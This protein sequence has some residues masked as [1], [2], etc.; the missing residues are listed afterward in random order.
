MTKI[1]DL[2]GSKAVPQSTSLSAQLPVSLVSDDETMHWINSVN[3]EWGKHI[4]P[5]MDEDEKLWVQEPYILKN[6]KGEDLE[7]VISVTMNDARVFGERVLSV[8]NE[9]D[10]LIEVNGQRNGK[11][12]DGHES[13]VIED[14]WYD[15]LYLANENLNQILMPDLDPYLWEQIGIRGRVGVRILLSQDENGFDVDILPIDMRKC[16]YSVGKRGLSKVAFWDTLDKD[17]CKEEY[18]DYKPVAE[19]IKRWDY[20]DGRQEII[21]LDGKPLNEMLPN[22][23]GHPP[24]VI[25]LCQQGTFLDTSSRALR[26]RGDSLFSANRELYPELNRISSILQTMNQLSLSPPQKLKS[27]SGKKFPVDP[28]Y[29]AGRILGLE[30]GEDIEKIESPDIQGSTRFFM[31]SL[32]GALQRGSI[33][34][35]DWGNL[36]FQLS[37]VAIATLAG[38]S[39]QVFTPRIKTMERFKRILCREAIQQFTTFKMSA[40]IGRTGK[41]RTYTAADLAGDY[42]VDF[43]YL[44]AL[45]EETA[46]AYGLANMAQRWMDDRS[47]RKTILR[48]RDYDDIDEK[49]LIQTAQKVSRALGLFQMAQSLDK[50]GRTDEAKV[51]LIEMGQSLQGIAPKEVTKITGVEVPEASPESKA[52]ALMTGPGAPIEGAVR[53]TRKQETPGGGEME[54]EATV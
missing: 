52:Q 42:T 29:R 2:K 31:A 8:L 17:M 3:A 28:V 46:A 23:L 51:L 18:P 27:K 34:N 48:Y 43:E 41:K 35:I 33:S 25:Q 30:I 10:E 50:Q 32:S 47:I 36:Q 24:F 15:L 21:F 16:V 26:M 39:K 1:A 11:E 54:E 13:K 45:P 9:S 7:D 5:R 53:T 37:Q 22:K 14:W 44:T 19:T 6:V 49:Y 4:F 12:L 38:A 20:W 40:S